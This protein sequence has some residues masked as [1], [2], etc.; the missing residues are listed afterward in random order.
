MLF[1][2]L[3]TNTPQIFSD[4]RTYWSPESIEKAT[5]WKPE[6]RAAAGLLDL[7]N[8]GSPRWMVPGKAVRDG[9]TSLSLVRTHRG[10]P[11]GHA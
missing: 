8:S 10:G 9:K 7:R 2:Y 5:G 3:L 4:V 6:G 11:R 1:G